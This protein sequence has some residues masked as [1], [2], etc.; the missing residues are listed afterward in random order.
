MDEVCA[1][2]I[3]LMQENSQLKEQ[4][5][6]LKAK[7]SSIRS[8]PLFTPS[9]RTTYKRIASQGDSV[10]DSVMCRAASQITQGI[11]DVEDEEDKEEYNEEIIKQC[12]EPMPNPYFASDDFLEAFENQCNQISCF[13]FHP[14]ME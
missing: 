12:N 6:V 4:I 9:T 2:C 14:L 13:P 3:R 11:L 10:S 7:G 1:N 8:L 5:A